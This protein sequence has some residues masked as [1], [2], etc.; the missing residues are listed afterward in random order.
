MKTQPDASYGYILSNGVEL[1][2]NQGF[3]GINSELRLSEGYDGS[4]EIFD[5]E[6]GR[7]LSPS[8]VSEIADYV[9][10]LWQQL[11]EK[12]GLGAPAE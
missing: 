8:E 7:L 12:Y 5:F 1:S 4:I 2:A 6:G 9:I 11:K 3:L 10:A